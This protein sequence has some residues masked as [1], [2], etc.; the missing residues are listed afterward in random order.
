MVLYHEVTKDSVE[1]ILT[2]GLKRTSRGDKGDKSDIIETDRF[3][4]DH[5]PTALRQQDVSRDDNLYA[6]VGTDDSLVDITNGATVMIKDYPREDS[7]LLRLSVDEAYCFVSDL[8]RYDAVKAA[9]ANHE[10]ATLTELVDEYWAN[11][12]P[13]RDFTIGDIVRPEIMITHNI[14][15]TQLTPVPA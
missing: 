10:T 14:P 7:V 12:T 13:L 2:D 1:K 4:D 9:I 11:L 8:D 3:L 15:P 6:F 5:R